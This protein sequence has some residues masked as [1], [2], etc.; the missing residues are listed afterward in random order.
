M[1]GNIQNY[2]IGPRCQLDPGVQASRHY[3]V[4]SYQVKYFF[5][6]LHSNQVACKEAKTVRITLKP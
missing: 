4:A 6:I 5:V 2:E 1:Y 3:L